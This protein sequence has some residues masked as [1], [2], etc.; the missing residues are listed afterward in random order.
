MPGNDPI[1]LPPSTATTTVRVIDSTATIHYPTSFFFTDPIESHDDIN[2]PAYSFLISSESKTHTRHV[3]FDLG[4]RKDWKTGLPGPFIERL[5]KVNANC[6]V[7]KDVQEILDEAATTTSEGGDLPRSK[8]I[9]AIIW[10]HHHFDHTGNPALFPK[11]VPLVVGPGFKEAVLPGYPADDASSVP[12]SDWE[13]RELIELDLEKDERAIQIGP[14]QALDYFSDGSFYLLSTPGHAPGHLSGLAR[15]TPNTFV[16]M[17]GDAAHHAGELRPTEYLPLPDTL[18]LPSSQRFAQSGCPGEI[19]A[20]LQ[21]NRK[22]SRTTPFYEPST[23]INQNS[24]EAI[25]SI[26]S[27][28]QLDASDDVIIILAH[29]R[30]LQ[31]KIPLFPKSITSWREDDLDAKTRWLFVDDFAGSADKAAA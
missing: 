24:Q 27:I 13:G 28:T 22:G 19:L 7:E 9:E 20:N 18:P 3:L 5:K 16:F 1:T 8:D 30:H 2:C 23:H 31:D 4:V 26:R 12:S 11:S 29:D 10:S 14:F 17:G 25:R 21:P 15:V 6:T